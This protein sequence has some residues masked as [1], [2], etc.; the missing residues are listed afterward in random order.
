M[1]ATTRRVQH[2]QGATEGLPTINPSSPRPQAIHAGLFLQRAAHGRPSMASQASA[3]SS[4]WSRW[5]LMPCSTLLLALEPAALSVFLLRGDIVTIL[6]IS[7]Q[8]AGITA[9]GNEQC[10]LQV[11]RTC[12]GHSC[13]A[14]KSVILAYFGKHSGVHDMIECQSLISK[15][16]LIN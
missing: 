16:K 14:S 6:T 15:S 3:C 8:I 11:A 4:C 12:T 9:L 10:G 1:G 2:T 5:T 13:I 7:V